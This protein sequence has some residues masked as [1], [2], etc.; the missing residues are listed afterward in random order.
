MSTLL[1]EIGCE[2]LPYKVCESV[3]RQ[4]EG[5]PE[6]PGL[7]LSLLGERA[8]ARGGRGGQG[9][10]LAAPHRRPGRRRARGAA[11][12]GPGVP[13]PQGRDRLRRGRH[14]HQ[15]GRRVRALQGRRGRGRAARG[16]RRHRVRRR[17]RRG[18]AARR[19]AR[20][21][22]SWSRAS[23]PA[24]RSRAACAGAP[25]RRARASTCGSRAP[26]AGSSA[27][28]DG[29]TLSGEFYG[30]PFGDVSQGH[31]VLGAPVTI[32]N[33]GDYE[34]LLEEQKVVVSQAERRR[35]IVDGLDAAA[36]RARRLVVRPRRRAAISA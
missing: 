21:S 36:E 22:P 4:L 24:C 11:G 29:E 9:P 7:A 23:S 12:P 32:A 28:L 20:S 27:K 1:I 14:A 10:G 8:P 5:T 17:Q 3:I 31:R 25:G 19:R 16:D 30:L 26:S 6:Q 13:R 34:R 18:R 35:R 2:E 15:G 33:A